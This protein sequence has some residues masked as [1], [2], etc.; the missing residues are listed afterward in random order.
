[1][2]EE[3]AKVITAENGSV[4]L[5]SEI[6]SSCN[7]CSQLKHCGSGQVAKALPHA[8]LQLT[9]EYDITDTGKILVPGDR[10]VLGLPEEQ[11][12]TSAGHV[13][14]LPL[15]G[16]ILFSAVGQWLYQW[17]LLS[18]ELFGLALGIAGG[19]AGFRLAKFL[20]N[21]TKRSAKLQPKIIGL[22]P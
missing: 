20:Q 14:L 18:H 8:K 17:Q 9:L 7:G 5:V 19:Y 6:S 15:A 21:N 3:R 4:T 11:I 10:V 1:M 13:Y 22:V 16:L 12:L 2:I